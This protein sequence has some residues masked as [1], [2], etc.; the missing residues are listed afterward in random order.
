MPRSAHLEIH[1]LN[2]S[3]GDSI[4]I[5]NRFLGKVRDNINDAASRNI[6]LKLPAERIDWMPYAVTNGIS[7]QGTVKKALIIDG[8]NDEFGG[9]VVAYLT[10][11]GVIDPS[12]SYQPKLSVLISHYHADHMDGLRSIFQKRDPPDSDTLVPNLRPAWV[13]QPFFQ[14]M[15]VAEDFYLLENAIAGATLTGAQAE[16]TK[17]KWIFPAGR[18]NDTEYN[19]HPDRSR[20]M[21]RQPSSP[22]KISLGVAQNR[23]PIELTVIAAGSSVSQGEEKPFV[24]VPG[25]SATADQND[26]SVVAMLEH[27]SFRMFFGGDIGGDGSEGGGNFLNNDKDTQLIPTDAVKSPTAHADLET[28]V[29]RALRAYFPA[30][31]EWQ[32]GQPKFPCDGY[33]TVMKADHHGSKSSNDVFLFGTLQPMLLL[34]SCG[35]RTLFHRHP[36][37]HVLNRASAT[38][39]P[40]WE[41]PDDDTP[42]SIKQVYITEVADTVVTSANKHIAFGGSLNLH[43]ARIVGD[44]VVRPVSESLLAI[45]SAEAPGTALEVQ[46]YGT[47]ASTDLSGTATTLMAPHA[48]GA[49][50]YPIGPFYHSDVH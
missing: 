29:E 33:A 49:P 42:N 34:I 3:Q 14:D 32:R 38:A 25:K 2:V 7:L 50:P 37:Q 5:I 18:D 28:P 9:D 45:Q 21:L 20:Q 46:V 15:K 48:A 24:R 30:T 44:I 41:T 19:P 22:T 11:H 12:T 40:D 27:G 26:R 17:V 13:Y 4:L 39:T 16:R 8:G 1:Q 10:T 35:F 6:A 23:L 36:T 43:G 47:N 31:E